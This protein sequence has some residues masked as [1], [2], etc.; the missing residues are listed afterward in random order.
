MHFFKFLKEHVLT[1]S[2]LEGFST[3]NYV[4]ADSRRMI[5]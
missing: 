5:W 1:I 4:E 2:I 3:N